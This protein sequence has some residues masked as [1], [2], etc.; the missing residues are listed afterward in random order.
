MA[1]ED[2]L[3]EGLQI[4]TPQELESSMSSGETNT[5]E[6]DSQDSN[7]NENGIT[8]DDNLFVP[9]DKKVIEDNDEDDS[10]TQST[11]TDEPSGN[12]AVYQALI[13]EMVSAGVLTAEEGEDAGELPGNLDTI[14][15]LMEKTVDSKTNA[16]QEA[17]KNSLSKSK[18][19]F[20]EIE[21]AFDDDDIAIQM[22]ERLE[23]F[24]S[25]TPEQL[26]ENP[27]LQ[28]QIYHQYLL[29]KGFTEAEAKEE[30]E[31]ADSLAKLEDKAGKALPQLRK[32]A[33]EY[34]DKARTAKT[35]AIENTKKQAAEKFENLIKTVESKE[36]FIDGINL[37]KIAREKLKDN[38]TKPVYTDEDG[39][40]YTSLM[41]KQ[42]Q[43]AAE[44]EM[45]INY[46]D[47]IGL[48]NMDKSGNFKPD[49]SKIK[50]AAKTK[51][52]SEIDKVIAENN[53]R[54]VGRNTSV[55]TSQSTND[56]LNALDGAFGKRK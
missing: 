16:K 53:S 44:F 8:D 41:H 47:T 14:K 2:E 32:E 17:W 21:D 9:S 20:F 51:A 13:K 31:D 48:F 30:V 28:K 36:S 19:R 3:F 37:N 24:D 7:S 56:L 50:A 54:G 29:G 11:N 49:I 34:V 43:N 10:S 35:E 6:D 38:I 12:E 1:K 55:E 40:Q 23:F 22:T 45:L 46:Y 15:S 18:K 52:I 42:K 33:N 4:M 25:L 26:S 5:N 27:D 39:R